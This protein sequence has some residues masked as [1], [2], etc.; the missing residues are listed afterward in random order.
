[1]NKSVVLFSLLCICAFYSTAQ[2]NPRFQFTPSTVNTD[3]NLRFK[4]WAVECIYYSSD[5][6][7]MANGTINKVYLRAGKQPVHLKSYH[8]YGLKVSMKATSLTSYP[9]SG[10][11]DSMLISENG[12]IVANYADLKVSDPM[13]SMW[14]PVP[15][16]V[17]GFSHSGGQNFVVRITIDSFE[18][19]PIY[20]S[21]A[22]KSL[23]GYRMIRTRSDSTIGTSV[24]QILDFG[25]DT[26]A[27]QVARAATFS[28]FKYVGL[29]PNPAIDGHFNVAFETRHP[30]KQV[31]I[32]MSDVTG[33]VLF[34]QRHDNLGT[35]GS[36]QI[37]PQNIASGV[38]FVRIE[39]DDFVI[40]RRITFK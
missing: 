6:P 22:S 35:A 25:F 11:M 36:K 37:A 4:H 30:V 13:D 40:V 9:N 20:L 21:K 31:R 19:A 14:I 26:G 33:R 23:L 7:G 16:N 5:F 38:Y 8:F 29:F 3:T 18:Y 12:N 2:V 17:A 32:T 1:M 15:L 24:N 27:A 39:A 10:S 34:S 28:N